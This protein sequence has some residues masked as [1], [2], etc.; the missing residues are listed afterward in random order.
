M[1]GDDDAASIT[2]TTPEADSIINVDAAPGFIVAS[3]VKVVDS[4]N[5]DKAVSTLS[6][7]KQGSD[8]RCVHL[9][10][11]EKEKSGACR[12]G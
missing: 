11:L 8:A 6:V 12:A 9:P 5:A 4:Q 1:T 3:Q 7:P 10:V 2:D